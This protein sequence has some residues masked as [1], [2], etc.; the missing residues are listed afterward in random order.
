MKN[1]NIWNLFFIIEL[2]V[3][4]SFVNA[5]QDY[6]KQIMKDSEI[7]E[8]IIIDRS[9]VTLVHE[10]NYEKEVAQSKK[11]VAIL[12][13]ATWCQPCQIF[14]PIYVKVAEECSDLFKFVHIDF[15]S[16]PLFVTRYDIQSVP[17][18]LFAIDGKIVEKDSAFSSRNDFRTKI[19]ATH[20]K[21]K[22]KYNF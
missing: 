7:C 1:K 5:D 18:V 10:K 14:K 4:T 9:K 6:V 22:N 11:P 17:T 16:Y 3:S 21:L 13:S 12:V 20:R 15:D 8:K 2:C 19:Y